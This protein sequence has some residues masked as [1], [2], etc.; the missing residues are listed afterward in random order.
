MRQQNT[1]SVKWLQYIDGLVKIPRIKNTFFRK[2]KN[3]T[4]RV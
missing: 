2:T 1:I 3:V 4:F